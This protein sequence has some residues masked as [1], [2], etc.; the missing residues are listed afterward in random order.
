MTSRK[1][2]PKPRSPATDKV[3]TEFIIALHA[4][5]SV[6]EEITNRI[7]AAL[8]SGQAIT[9]PKLQEALYPAEQSADK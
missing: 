9:G 6:G 8:S 2:T 1:V 5:P 3:F 7:Q 4:E